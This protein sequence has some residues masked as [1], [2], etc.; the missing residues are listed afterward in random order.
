M[1]RK[2]ELTW[3]VGS[4]DRKGRW[5]KKYK[6]KS[7][8]FAFGSSKSDVE[9]YRQALAAWKEKKSEID[10]EEARRERPHQA[11]YEAAIQEWT[12]VLAWSRENSD[13]QYAGLALAKLEL[14]K[15]RLV[16]SAPPPL[17]HDDRIWGQFTYPR[18]I[19]D[20]IG[21]AVALLRPTD[22]S[23]P[24]V[25]VPT[26]RMI[27]SMDGTPSRIRTEVWKDRLAVQ[28]QKN[29]ETQETVGA[30]IDTF[31]ATE[32]A[33]VTAGEVSAG[34]FDPL[35]THLH[36][37]RDWLGAGL[38]LKSITSKVL[39]DYHAE[40]LQG[41]VEKKWSADYTKDRMNAVKQLVRWLWRIEAI[42]ELPRVLLDKK[43]LKVSRKIGTPQVFT[44]DEAKKLLASATP[45]TKLYLL[46]MANT[47]MTQKDISDLRQT[48]VDWKE[49]RI[50]RKRSKTAKY[51][52]VPVVTYKLWGETFRLLK[53][54]RSSDPEVVLTNAGGGRLK[55]EKLDGNG[56]LLKID[57]VSSAFNRLKRA[58]KISKPLK[59]FR[60]TSA[61]LLRGE[62]LFTG[63]ENLF[64]GH[65]PRTMSDRH[66]AQ[67]PQALLDEA[68]A[69]LGK[70]FGTE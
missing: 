9:G 33:R 28:R 59:A 20:S 52:G 58:T 7:Y 38:P 44:V 25:I 19:L 6:G 60:K 63:V 10:D 34:R 50:T 22:P 30:N 54:E 11:E 8:Y 14:L 31:L 56:K 40:L 67:V 70:Q 4:G 1:P 48:E 46:L 23:A 39:L 37:F 29:Q 65:S 3:Q 57:N 61:T 42:N 62:R 35:R 15:K 36:H 68:I 64:L 41:L 24:G 55:V 69:W 26:G 51:D 47:G 13:Q 12:L 18:E 53:E 17:G 66:Y 21:S 2:I 32:R 45:R 16:S 43:S 27:E 49:G 5:R